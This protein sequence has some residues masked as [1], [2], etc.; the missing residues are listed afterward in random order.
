MPRSLEQWLART[1]ISRYSRDENRHHPASLVPF[2][3]LRSLCPGGRRGHFLMFVQTLSEPKI[4][5][6]SNVAGDPV[7]GRVSSSRHRT[8]SVLVWP[9][10]LREGVQ[11]VLVSWSTRP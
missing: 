1:N 10:H 4:G 9:N 8:A 11:H 2:T 7:G 3:I 5:T 6:F